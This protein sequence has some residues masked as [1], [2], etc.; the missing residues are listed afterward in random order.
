MGR[1]GTALLGLLV[2]L[3]PGAVAE[4]RPVSGQLVLERLQ[5]WLRRHPSLEARF[6]QVNRWVG[7]GGE[8]DTALGRMIVQQPCCFRLEYEVPPGHLLT[9]D[10]ETLW[11]YVPDIPQVV[12]T[13]VPEEGTGAGDLFLWVLERARPD[14]LAE[15]GADSVARL[16][17]E[18]PPDFGW[19]RAE[20]RVNMKNGAPVAYR[21][22]DRQGNVT[23]FAFKELLA[24]PEKGPEAFRFT[25][26]PG[27]EVV[28]VR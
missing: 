18:P 2:A 9:C 27:V 15:M 3:A 7:W 6:V 14:S 16:G 8:P 1:R 23:T 11:N 22:E 5:E 24:I 17:I 26:P 19:Q 28:D 20:I 13:A 4:A 10:G 25:P 21:Y 12:R